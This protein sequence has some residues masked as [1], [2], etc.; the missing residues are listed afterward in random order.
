M[1]FKP[2]KVSIPPFYL[3][4]E[5]WGI[6][7]ISNIGLTKQA[8]FLFGEPFNFNVDILGQQGVGSNCSTLNCLGKYLM[9][10]LIIILV[11]LALLFEDDGG[12]AG[13]FAL[14]GLLVHAVFNAVGGG[15]LL[16][17]FGG[18]VLFVRVLFGFVDLWL[19]LAFCHKLSL[20][21]F[22]ALLFF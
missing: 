11:E 14:R 9:S 21:L 16:F 5:C 10:A 19:E 4:I 2:F 20:L 13:A 7:N 17:G 1:F 6:N 22:G 3:Y 12:G 8:T 15:G 18:F